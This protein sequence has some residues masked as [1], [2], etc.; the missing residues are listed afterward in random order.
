LRGGQ[1]I[2]TSGGTAS[3]TTVSNGGS[4]LVE[5]GGRVSGTVVSSGGTEYVFTGGVTQATAIH[6]GG[7]ETVDFGGIA[8]GSVISGGAS[9]VDYGGTVVDTVVWAGGGQF[10]YSGGTVTGT[11]VN[12]GGTETIRAG[13][14]VTGT[15][16]NSGG[17]IDLPDFLYDP[18]GSVTLDPDVDLL[19]VTAAGGVYEQTLDGSYAAISF[20]AFRDAG[21]GTLLTAGTNAPCFLAGTTIATEDGAVAPR[22]SG[23]VIAMS[24]APAIRGPSRFGR[25]G[26]RKTH[27]DRISRV[28]T[29]S[30]RRI[31]RSS[32]AVS[33]SRCGI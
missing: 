25:Y 13:E 11:I 21:T 18:A 19:T 12:S 27:S 4:L 32:R 20:R 22:S 33:S 3:S 6:P 10:V 5:D 14:V 26:W 8:S 28:A 7:L 9:Y 31:T 23:S 24:T 1:Q 29:C 16:V 17:S 2:V 30:C 15:I